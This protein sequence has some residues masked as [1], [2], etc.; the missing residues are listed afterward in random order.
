MKPITTCQVKRSD[1]ELL[2]RLWSRHGDPV[3]L[4]H[5]GPG[6]PDYMAPVADLLKGAWR[7]IGYD[8]RGAGNSRCGAACGPAEHI[9]DLAAIADHLALPRFHLFG[10][11]WGGLLAQLFAQRYPERLK[12]LFLCNAMTGVGRDYASMQAAL[13]RYHLRAG[14]PAGWARM[15]LSMLLVRIPGLTGDWGARLLYQQVW[16]NYAEY[17]RTR[18]NCDT[19]WL[20]GIQRR[21]VYDGLRGLARLDET[22]LAPPRF[23]AELPMLV[24]YGSRDPFGTEYRKVFR[25]YPWARR[26]ILP[27]CGHLPW[28]QNPEA[29]TGLL[30]DFYGSFQGPHKH[31]TP[32]VSM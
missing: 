1:T 31:Q 4:L 11:S 28:Q 16:R 9:A 2:V 18:A 15:G 29:F 17:N 10:H 13:L 30:G 26:V 32:C 12:S 3:I 8:Q 23:G 25:R 6:M 27:E 7:V 21:P 14:G 19:R 20:A 22:Y 24:L 5:G